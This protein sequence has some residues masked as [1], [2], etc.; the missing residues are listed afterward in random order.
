MSHQN[1]LVASARECDGQAIWTVQEANRTAFYEGQKND[2][3]LVPLETIHR[4]ERDM[5]RMMS[6]RQLKVASIT[7]LT[8]KMLKPLAKESLLAAIV[9]QYGD[10]PGLLFA[11]PIA[12][13]MILCPVDKMLNFLQYNLRLGLIAV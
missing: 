1:D 12:T 10:F 5:H 8:R 13:Y 7:I 3:C 11:L 2:V 4:T 9:R 6:M